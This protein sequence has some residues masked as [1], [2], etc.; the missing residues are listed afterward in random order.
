ML[1]IIIK[2]VNISC[3]NRINQLVKN[4]TDLIKLKGIE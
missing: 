1:E 4:S 2:N 3:L